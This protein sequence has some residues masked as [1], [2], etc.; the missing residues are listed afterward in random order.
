MVE[1]KAKNE[2]LGG[3]KDLIKMPL[4]DMHGNQD[5]IAYSKKPLT[6]LQK[7][8]ISDVK[9]IDKINWN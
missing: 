8:M 7:K 1:S 2:H 3:F 4:T 9:D 5:A 6:E